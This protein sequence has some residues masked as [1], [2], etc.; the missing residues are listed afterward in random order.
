LLVFWIRRGVHEPEVWTARRQTAT[1]RTN[2]FA[3]LFGPALLRR[4]LMATLLTTSVMFAYW[5]LFTWL[6]AFLATPV[7]DGGAGMSVVKSLGWII[8]MQIGAFFGY[9]DR[10]GRRLAFM[11][12]LLTAAVLVPI[13][14]NMGRHEFVLMALG[15]VLGFVGHG[16]FSLFGA[17]L[18]EL[19]PTA[20]R[21]TGQGVTYNAGRAVSALAPFSIG[22][23]AEEHGIGPALGLTSAFFV[24]GA[25]LILLVPDTSGKQ[26][27]E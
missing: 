2:P 4:T 7:E 8:P 9:L 20:V 18:A 5:G 10:I 6:P 13:Y 23:L 21:A 19:F 1:P 22:L 24:L 17:L 16:Y 27:D 25:V 15:P 11:L 14:G 26:L 12:F 3:Q